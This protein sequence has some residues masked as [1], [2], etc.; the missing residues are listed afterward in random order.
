MKCRHLTIRFVV[1]FLCVIATAISVNAQKQSDKDYRTKREQALRLFNQDKR[2]EALPLLEMLAQRNPDDEDV[3]IA[4]AAS[5][6]SHAATLTDQQAAA[7]ER[8]R[9]KGLLEKLGSNYPLAGNL[10]QL[11]REM[12]EKD[13]VQFSD[14]PAVEQ[15]M[16]TGEAAFSR[17]DYDDALKNYSRTLE[18]EPGN[19]AATLFIG[20]TF[21]KK[22]DYAKAEEWYQKAIQLDP[23]IETAYRYYA[24][25][26][27]RK[28]EM[29]KSRSMLIHAVVA[30]PYNRMVWRDLLTWASL[31]ETKLNFKYAG[32]LSDPKL[33]LTPEPAAA[34]QD[35]SPF[36]VRL[37]K[38]RPRDLSDAWQAYQ[39]VREDWKN[40]KFKQHFPHESVYR[41]SLT[42]ETEALI[43]EVRALEQLKSD[44]ETAELV[45]E[46]YSLRLLLQLHEAGVLEPYILLRLG[47][48]DIAKD[49]AAYR[50]KHRDKL[51]EYV[52]KFVVPPATIKA[53]SLPA[54]EGSNAEKGSGISK[55]QIYK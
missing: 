50:T 30:E 25:M 11:L 28:G 9:A 54:K 3:V 8:M 1:L 26:L 44:I 45:T 14:N 29:G 15:A 2:L 55:S 48:E 53:Q 16:R 23:N 21:F 7:G 27:A 5:L 41:H 49:Y 32:L 31:N 17:R 40:S 42:E 6:V 10:L 13:N 47:D 37:F 46:D 33:A 38:D 19:Y 51:E 34:A 43:V 18:L 22:N 20:N 39:S 24:E 12:P 36:K 52:D 4:L 35:A